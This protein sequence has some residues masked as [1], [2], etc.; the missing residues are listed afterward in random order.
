MSKIQS[1]ALEH[2]SRIFTSKADRTGGVARFVALDDVSLSFSRGE[3][4]MLLGENGAG[5]STLV[6]IL[7]GLDQ[8]GN[9]CILIDKE[10]TVFKS[11]AQALE[12]GIAMVHQRPLL[13]DNLTVLE[14]ITLAERGFLV[15]RQ[16]LEKRLEPLMHQWNCELD[17]SKPV[18]VLS[19]ADRLRTALLC[20]LITKPAF[21]ILD[22]P[23]A[24]L[25]PDERTK[26]MR[27]LSES[28]SEG[29]G[30]MV[31]TH[32]MQEAAQW[33]DRISVL[34]RGKLVQ[35]FDQ[36]ERA[37]TQNQLVG[38]FGAIQEISA[39]KNTHLKIQSAEDR[40]VS[41]FAISNLSASPPDKMHITNINFSA[42]PGA[43]TGI[44]AYPGSGLDT[45]EE[46]LTGMIAADSGIITLSGK[47]SSCINLDART[48]SPSKLR[49]HGI[50]FVPSNRT[51]RGSH[52]DIS[53][54]DALIP[55]LSGRFIMNRHETDSFVQEQIHANGI[56]DHPFRPVHTL[57]GGQLQKL[58]LSRELSTTPRVLIL[59]DPEWGL[60]TA[61]TVQLRKTL[62][63]TAKAGVTIIILTDTPD[64]MDIHDFFTETRI[65]REGVLA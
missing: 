63:E 45:L 30:I 52:P 3:L 35:S 18:R 57:S 14:N 38:L 28:A 40:C 55:Y 27:M 54:H 26:F 39:G 1:V 37:V 17:L 60:D 32:K 43:I 15:H 49:L 12:R 53:I 8:P 19:P 2:V 9:G 41:G 16:C 44:L 58:I 59:S 31:I 48:L 25:P 42:E 24:I 51:M 5:K 11:P 33:G 50:A 23:T 21:L 47:D 62:R 13:A 34:Q 20:A 22:E 6:H 46:V 61:S 4:H 36:K 56:A 7:S 10:K 65:L 64:T 29:T